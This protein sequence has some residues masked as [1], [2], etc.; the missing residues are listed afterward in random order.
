MKR[1]PDSQNLSSQGVQA[2]LASMETLDDK[3]NEEKSA[4]GSK[5]T[6]VDNKNN[7]KNVE[8]QDQELPWT[9][10]VKNYKV[11]IGKSLEE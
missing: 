5:N 11:A 7:K 6:A 2:G 4:V 8:K 1:S 9:Q 10:K 3:S